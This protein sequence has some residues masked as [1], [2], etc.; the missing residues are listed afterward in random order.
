MTEA[1]TAVTDL[2]YERAVAELEGIVND[3]DQ[4]VVDVDTLSQRFQ[5]AI[6]IIEELD[7]RIARTRQQ[8]DQLTP[9]LE[10]IAGQRPTRGG[11][12]EASGEQG[13]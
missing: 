11:D 8:V 2:T 13:Y 7:R 6:D 12:D 9:R 4:G 10:A 5:R 3:L 1:T